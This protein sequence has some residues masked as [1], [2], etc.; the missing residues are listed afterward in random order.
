MVG[1]HV[2]RLRGVL[3]ALAIQA[4][5]QGDALFLEEHL[6]HAAVVAHV[7]LLVHILEG[8]RV[9][10]V[11]DAD[12]VVQCD[13]YLFLFSIFVGYGRQWFQERLHFLEQHRAARA[14][15]LLEGALVKIL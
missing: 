6:D 3:V 8:H 1:R 9:V 10:L 15:A 5:V 12:V 7:D 14:L 2:F 11:V 4:L 13:R